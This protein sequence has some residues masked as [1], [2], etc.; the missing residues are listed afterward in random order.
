MDNAGTKVLNSAIALPMFIFSLTCFFDTLI[1][2]KQK[3]STLAV[4]F[5]LIQ[6]ILFLYTCGISLMVALDLHAAPDDFASQFQWIY[7]I[8]LLYMLLDFFFIKVDSIKNSHMDSSDTTAQIEAF[9][10]NLHR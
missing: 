3:K 1:A 7:C 4:I 10:H 2:V 6:L 8:V 9:L 5:F